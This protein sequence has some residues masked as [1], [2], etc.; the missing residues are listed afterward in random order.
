MTNYLL[1]QA[2]SPLKM[3]F[4]LHKKQLTLDLVKKTTFY[5]AHQLR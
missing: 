4:L 3:F 1:I 2:R 5:E